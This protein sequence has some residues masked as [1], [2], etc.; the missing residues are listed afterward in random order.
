[1]HYVLIANSPFTIFNFRKELIVELF[2]MGHSISVV[3]P[4]DCKIKTGK[5]DIESYN[6]N[7][8]KWKLN[9]SSLNPF[10]EALSLFGLYRALKCLKPD[11]VLNYTIKATI[12]GSFVSKILGVKKIYSNITG[13]GYIFINEG[14]KNKFI[15]MLVCLQYK[16]ALRF[17]NKVFFQN[18]DDMNLF[19]KLK[20]LKEKNCTLINGSGVD[21]TYFF[22]TGRRYNQGTNI[23]FLFVGRILR[24]KGILELLEAFAMFKL[25]HPSTSLTLVG[26]I[27]ENRSRISEKFIK[28]YVDLGTITFLGNITDVKAQYSSHDVFILPSYREGTPRSTLEAM[29][30]GMP[31]IT[32][33][34][35]GCRETVQPGVNGI[36]VPAKSVVSL[37][38]AMESMLVS[39]NT[40]ENMGVESRKIAV[41]KYDVRLVNR[42]IINAILHD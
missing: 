13:L 14:M 36:L 27:D 39:P 41:K 29:S 2:K 20:L 30:M 7:I 32:T 5:I 33:D 37:Y 9:R 3:F 31:I 12:Y 38:D 1:M 23:K 35:P 19:L 24:D 18:I 21:T 11:V 4:D 15:L 25:K 26:A 8:V 28:R 42:T 34:V 10:S 6:I 22:D 16:M 40:R 17:N